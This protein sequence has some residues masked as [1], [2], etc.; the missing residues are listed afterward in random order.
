MALIIICYFFLYHSVLF[1]F[2]LLMDY[3]VY[4]STVC[5]YL[6]KPLIT[7]RDQQCGT[8]EILILKVE[9]KLQQTLCKWTGNFNTLI[10][11]STVRT[12]HLHVMG[13][14]EKG[15]RTNQT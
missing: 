7:N 13:H 5:M 12:N 14:D 9:A 6:G 15:R 1:F 10:H 8:G 3:D 4:Q 11:S 2:N